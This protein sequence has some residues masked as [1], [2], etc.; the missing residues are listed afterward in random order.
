LIAIPQIVITALMVADS[1]RPILLK[2]SLP[3]IGFSKV[4]DESAFLAHRS[5]KLFVRT[6]L[7]SC[8][9]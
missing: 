3:R 4:V 2:N 8:S 5:T 7:I 9:Q 1:F 6:E